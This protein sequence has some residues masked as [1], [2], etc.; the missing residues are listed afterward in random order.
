MNYL[1]P[2]T[3]PRIGWVEYCLMPGMD[4]S[5]VI[6]RLGER[7]SGFVVGDMV[8]GSPQPEKSG[9]YASFMPLL[10][11]WLPERWIACL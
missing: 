3:K 11:T 2:L 8:F 9:T 5:G 10:P 4:F 1:P 6:V 7:V